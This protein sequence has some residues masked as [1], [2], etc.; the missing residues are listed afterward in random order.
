MLAGNCHKSNYQD[1]LLICRTFWDLF[2]TFMKKYN[3]LN[4]ERNARN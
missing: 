1:F 2:M 4:S 3:N